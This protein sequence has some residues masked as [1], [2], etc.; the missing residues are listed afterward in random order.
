MKE[1]EMSFKQLNELKARAQPIPIGCIGGQTFTSRQT[2]TNEAWEILGKKLGFNYLTVELIEKG[3]RFFLAEPTIPDEILDEMDDI[4]D[5]ELFFD[6]IS[7]KAID[8]EW[9]AKVFNAFGNQKKDEVFSLLSSAYREFL[10]KV[11]RHK[12]GLSDE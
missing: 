11:A 7:E 3:E 4:S 5:Q 12:L 9:A 6:S 10:E 1:Y 8:E 2:R